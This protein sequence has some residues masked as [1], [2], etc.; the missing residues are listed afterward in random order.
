MGWWSANKE[1]HSLQPDG[2][3]AW[4]D[5]PAD[6]MDDALDRIDAS[7]VRELGR[8]PSLEEV[9]AGLLFSAVP[10]YEVT[11]IALSHPEVD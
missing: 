11:G 1:G 9:K 7:F 10:R 8:K 6:A 5:E 3:Y 4:G 2:A